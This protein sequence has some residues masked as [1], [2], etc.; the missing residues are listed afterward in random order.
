ATGGAGSG[1]AAAA[2]RREAARAAARGQ[3][4]A[5]ATRREDAVLRAAACLAIVLAANP[6]FADPKAEAI[7]L[8][9]QG[10]KDMQAG[11]YDRACRELAASLAKYTDSGTKGA[12]ADCETHIG[13][14][15]SA[16]QRWRDLADTAPTPDL[17]ADAASR[18]D[19][20]AARLAHFVVKLRAGA[21]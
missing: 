12:L 11:N 10:I 17:R 5:D 8:F 19:K 20:L 4:E 18:A 1:P 6:A 14:L 15:A 16:W 9:D 7:V 2:A 13:K 3:V 21:P